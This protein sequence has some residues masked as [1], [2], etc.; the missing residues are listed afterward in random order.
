MRFQVDRTHYLCSYEAI[1]ELYAHIANIM[2]LQDMQHDTNN[3]V[4]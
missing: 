2:R 4:M 1:T 3:N